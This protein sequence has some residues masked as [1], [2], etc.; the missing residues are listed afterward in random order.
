MSKRAGVRYD[1]T[2]L[3]LGVVRPR[4]SSSVVGFHEHG[5]YDAPAQI[6]Y[7]LRA[8]QRS[9]LLYIGMSQGGLMFFTMTSERPE[10]SRKVSCAPASC[11][12]PTSL[13]LSQWPTGSETT[14]QSR[15]IF[16]YMPSGKQTKLRGIYTPVKRFFA[17]LAKLQSQNTWTPC[18]AAH[19]PRL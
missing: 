10:Y 15:D 5:V 1:R 12:H 7:I 14:S 4:L 18:A 13:A 16:L 19:G 6:D 8:T 9:E 3:G 11:C 2:T 17:M